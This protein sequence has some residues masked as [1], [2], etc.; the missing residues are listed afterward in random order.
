MENHEIWTFTLTSY[1]SVL[2]ESLIEEVSRGI[3]KGVR[4]YRDY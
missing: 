2:T 1:L 4:G 3:V